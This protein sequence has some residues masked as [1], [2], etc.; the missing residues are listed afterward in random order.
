M[1]NKSFYFSR[2]D[3]LF[4]F[5]F[6]FLTQTLQPRFFG[7]NTTEGIFHVSQPFKHYWKIVERFMI[8]SMDETPSTKPVHVFYRDRKRDNEPEEISFVF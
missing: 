5:I 3:F 2:G 4:I 1:R 8:P 7:R 6:S